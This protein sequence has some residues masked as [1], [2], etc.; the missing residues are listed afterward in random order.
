MRK[1]LT[2]LTLTIPILVFSQEPNNKDEKKEKK[3][4]Y[5]WDIG[6]N[7]GVNIN[8]PIVDDSPIS[9]ESFQGNLYGLTLI[10]HFNRI[11]ALKADFDIENRGWQM[12]EF[13]LPDTSTSLEDVTQ[14]LNYFDIPAFMHIGFGNK[15]KID[16]NLGPY[17]G[18]KVKD[19]IVSYE[20]DGTQLNDSDT[21]GRIG[22]S[23][24]DNIDF[25]VVYGIGFDYQFNLEDAYNI[26]EE[27]ITRMPGI[28]SLKN[29]VAE[30]SLQDSSISKS[31]YIIINL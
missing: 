18:F 22:I 14:V 21:R 13:Q 29:L 28:S 11:F 1:L 25:G 6:I 24:F 19:E 2:I 16:L 26:Q 23:K 27:I 5:R 17:V 10:Y 15:F 4:I 3:G 8:N 30:E 20:P 9:G 7:G 12:D 31:N